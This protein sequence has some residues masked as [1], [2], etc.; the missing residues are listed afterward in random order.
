[1][2][3]LLSTQMTTNI[4]IEKIFGAG[5]FQ[6]ANVLVIQKA[7]L[8]M[9]IPS[10]NN[11][12]ESLLAAILLLASQLTKAQLTANSQPITINGYPL[13][14]KN[15]S[16]Y[17]MICEKWDTVLFPPG[18]TRCTFLIHSFTDGN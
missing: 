4:P 7:S 17:S 9:L 8:P 5:F 18:K 3:V 11:T 16:D 15:N 14:I 1:M 6:D 13:I 12:A 10:S 2:P